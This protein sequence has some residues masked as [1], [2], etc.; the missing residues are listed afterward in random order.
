MAQKGNP[1]KAMIA[2]SGEKMVDGNLYSESQINGFS[3]SETKEHF[4]SDEY[5]LL[6]VANKYLTGFDQP[7]LCAMY[8]DKPLTGVLCVQALSR[9]NHSSSKYGK[10]AEDLF[11]LDF[12]NEAC[13]IQVAFESF[14]TQTELL[15]ETDINILHDLQAELDDAGVY[16]L[17]E[18]VHFVKGLF[19]GA[20]MAELQA[21]NQVCVG[22]FNTMLNWERRQKVE[23]KIRAKQFVK[24]YNQMASIIAFENLEWERRYWF[25]KLLIPKLNVTEEE[26]VIDELLQKVDLSSYAL[27]ITEDEHKIKL[28]DDTGTFTPNN[29]NVHGVHE[30]GKEKDS[31]DEIVKQFNERWFDGWGD[32]PE[33]RKIKFITVVE[34]VKQHKD[35]ESKYLTTLDPMLRHSIFSDIVKD[36]MRERREQEKSIYKQFVKDSSFQTA[37]LQDLERAVA[38]NR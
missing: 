33:E 14:Y 20:D 8:V 32:T 31:L 7:K 18:V 6:V 17:D 21:L 25:L 36:V 19:A 15:G 4:D 22:R 24:V 37:F 5:R 29:S 11:I 28:S 26:A 3:D 13:D 2:F 34:K 38:I 12:F 16:E 27:A 1:F 9:L 10:K 23:F 30:E 35:F